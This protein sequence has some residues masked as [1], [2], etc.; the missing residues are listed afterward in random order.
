M[1]FAL[2]LEFVTVENIHMS[3]M[4]EI[5][6][7]FL[8]T[9]EIGFVQN[10]P[11]SILIIIVTVLPLGQSGKCLAGCRCY[12]DV[13]SCII[14]YISSSVHTLLHHHPINIIWCTL[15]YHH[16]RRHLHHQQHQQI[17]FVWLKLGIN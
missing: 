16:R 10:F 4:I 17:R 3:L 11:P 7:F 13:I 2:A 5:F 1:T 8:D 14:Q 15:L 9:F 12:A 6:H